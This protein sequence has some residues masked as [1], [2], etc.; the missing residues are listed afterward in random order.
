MM[1]STGALVEAFFLVFESTIHK[2]QNNYRNIPTVSYTR[3]IYQHNA[4]FIFMS[5][6][7]YPVYELSLSLGLAG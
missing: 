2:N 5:S 7:R 6:G 1:V 4:F 3:I